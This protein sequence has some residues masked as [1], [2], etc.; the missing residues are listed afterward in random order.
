MHDLVRAAARTWSAT[1]AQSERDAAVARLLDWYLHAADTATRPVRRF[2]VPAVAQLDPPK[3]PGPDIRD[4]NG[5][6]A[7]PEA[8]VANLVAVAATA[9]AGPWYPHA[10]QLPHLLQP[11][12]IRRGLIAQWLATAQ[13]AE[14]AAHAAGSATGLAYARTEVGYAMATSGQSQPALA[15]LRQALE[16]HRALGDRYGEAVTHNH[17]AGVL[18]RLGQHDEA[19]DHHRAAVELFRLCGDKTREASTLSNLSVQLHLLGRHD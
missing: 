4:A 5:A 10:M 19:A 15:H 17:L 14:T 13:L 11:Y 9:A 12:L 16:L 7:W 2:A 3:S 1:D 8:A 18:R 6:M